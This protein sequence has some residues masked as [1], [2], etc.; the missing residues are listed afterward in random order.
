MR[1]RAART[2]LVS[3]EHGALLQGGLVVGRLLELDQPRVL[4]ILKRL[5]VRHVVDEQGT[6]GPAVVRR[7]DGAVALLS[8]WK[9]V[10]KGE[11]GGL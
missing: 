9:V 5:F 4:G 7:R 6:S 3:D 11:G 8:S 10:G 2:S 1:R